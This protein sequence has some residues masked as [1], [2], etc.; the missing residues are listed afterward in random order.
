MPVKGPDVLDCD[1]IGKHRAIA[2]K[3]EL[4]PERDGN[5]RDRPAQTGAN[6]Q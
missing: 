4:I 5:E 1:G 2:I 3:L 6:H